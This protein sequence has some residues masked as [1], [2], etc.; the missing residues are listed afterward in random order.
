[1]TTGER[2]SIERL[3]GT[4]SPACNTP[5]HGGGK[6]RDSLDYA[7]DHRS[8]LTRFLRWTHLALGLLLFALVLAGCRSN[9]QQDLIARELRMQED[10]L[11][12]MEDY[13]SQYQQ[14]VCKYRSENAALRRQM[15]DGY[16]EGDVDELPRPGTSVRPGDERR[17]PTFRA[18]QAPQRNEPASDDI[19]IQV[20]E[21][22]PLEGSTSTQRKSQV[23]TASYNETSEYDGSAAS[24]RLSSPKSAAVEETATAQSS[25]A[26]QPSNEVSLR[27]E[28]I[29]ND[30]GGGPR[31][32]VDVER[33][34]EAG[35]GTAF[36]GT[37]SLLLL[38]RIEENVPQNLAR[39]DFSAADV[40]SA[41]EPSAGKH[42]MRFYLELPTAP[43]TG[44]PT[45]VWVRLLPRDGAKL[46]AHAEIDLRQ[47]GDFA[48]NHAP[49]PTGSSQAAPLVTKSSST[50]ELSSEP[51]SASS[52]SGK[53]EWTTAR[54]DQLAQLA[55][56]TDAGSWRA[57][58]EPMPV[59]QSSFATAPVS[60]PVQR[61]AF[62]DSIQA[63]KP[64][65]TYARPTWSP[66]RSESAASRPESGA[67][68]RTAVTQRPVWS[69]T[70]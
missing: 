26:D 61:A 40:R 7:L 1:L 32:M 12:A 23:A 33:L 68:Q 45:E 34:D 31:L 19:Q 44:N 64:V 6:A 11:Y 63:T 25:T 52:T 21:V 66:D 30:S 39:W 42:A 2:F 43:A 51:P 49:P 46:L 58:S 70:R 41:A 5:L 38:E 59:V 48:S 27:G 14:L 3:A 24:T 17:G 13:I 60:R 20:P 37:L 62:F 65:R 67:G 55:N 15:A 47:P 8:S 54:S 4:P 69:D 22:P 28:V 9:A 29:V 57:S 53:G 35:H 50:N 36:V 16:Y 10:Q 18:P 56:G